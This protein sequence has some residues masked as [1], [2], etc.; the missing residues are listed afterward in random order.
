MK[1]ALEELNT[2]KRKK[3]AKMLEKKLITDVVIINVVAINA[4]ILA[5]AKWNDVIVSS[6]IAKVIVQLACY[7]QNSLSSVH[8]SKFKLELA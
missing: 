5:G 8:R 4:P 1:A 7:R 6:V 3:R 2:N